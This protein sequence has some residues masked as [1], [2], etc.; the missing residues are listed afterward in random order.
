M[1]PDPKKSLKAP[2]NPFPHD[3][4]RTLAWVELYGHDEVL[5]SFLELSIAP[6]V[7][8]LVFTSETTWRNTPDGFKSHPSITWVV[9]SAHQSVPEFLNKNGCQ[10]EHCQMV[11]FLTISGDYR[12]FKQKKWPCPSVLILHNAGAWL[13]PWKFLCLHTP[14]DFLRMLK[15]SC[16]GIPSAQK[17]IIQIM[18]RIGFPTD[19]IRRH[20]ID[21][22][23]IYPEK[24]FPAL[25]FGIYQGKPASKAKKTGPVR[26][27]LP[28]RITTKARD[29]YGVFKAFQSAIPRFSRPVQFILLGSPGNRRGKKIQYDFQKL[30]GPGFSCLTFG[31]YIPQ[32]VYQQYLENA[33]FLLLPIT[34][35]MRYSI[36]CEHGG[37]TKISGVENDMI[38]YAI[39]S[40]VPSFY[41]LDPALEALTARYDHPAQLAGLLEEWV[42]KE[43]VLASRSLPE[44]AQRKYAL[45]GR[46]EYFWQAVQVLLI[47][48]Y[49]AHPSPVPDLF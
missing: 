22:G 37:L 16:S 11:F 6:F 42:N 13:R 14:L 27:V 41:N 23:W 20:C 30:A 39:P 47:S 40:L 36:F 29:Y 28:G 45:Q 46:Q 1:E 2:E 49:D 4:H 12:F 48:L 3:Q 21:K 38:R 17:K 34:H 10:F 43:E 18:D 24:T 44:G 19:Q 26:I 15:W 5:W 9:K 8:L 35:R 32:P 31:A 33:D 7:S 25:P